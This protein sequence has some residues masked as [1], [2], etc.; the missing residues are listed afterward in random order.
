VS[1][2]DELTRDI[3]VGLRD[4]KD[5]LERLERLMMQIALGMGVRPDG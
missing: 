4:L 2:E 3:L 1:G 5:I